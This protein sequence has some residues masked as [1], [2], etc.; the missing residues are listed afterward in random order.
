MTLVTLLRRSRP[1]A[2]H[3]AC[4]GPLG[5]LIDRSIPALHSG[6]LQLV[7][8][9]S[10]VIE[11]RGRNSGP[12][13]K[14]CA[15]RWRALWRML[16]DGEDGFADGYLD[17]DWSTP[18]L[19]SVLDLCARNEAALTQQAESSRL[20]LARNKILHWLRS[21]TRSGSRRNIKTH[22]DLGNDFFAPWLNRGM[23]YSSALYAGN[24]PMETAQDAKLDRI[25]SLLELKG[26]ERILRS[27]AAGA[28]LPNVCSGTLAGVCWRSRSRP[29]N[30]TM[31]ASVFAARLNKAAP[32][33][34]CWITAIFRANSIA[35]YRSR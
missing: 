25:A 27:A 2:R 9:N 13:A 4:L 3:R 29:S 11:R 30:S 31:R 24:E 18:D 6:R 16:V 21:N 15:N 5:R 34:G 19:G 14:L 22:Y 23:N 26:G 12:D 35:S 8:P 10:E 33:S 7:L 17:G 20:R 32:I 1:R 28:R